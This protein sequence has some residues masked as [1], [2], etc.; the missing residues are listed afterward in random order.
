[1][2]K[3]M[4]TQYAPA[5]IGPYAQAVCTGEFVFTSGQIA[6]ESKTGKMVQGGIEAQTIKVI[7]NIKAVLNAVGLSLCDIVKTMVFVKNL[8]DFD[9]VND[10]YA[11][12]FSPPYPARSCIEAA[13]LPKDALIEI[14]AVA[15]CR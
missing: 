6:L 1:M 7:D 2:R 9:V 8:D 5:A 11:Q 10:V 3:T 4:N 13:R 15:Q 14:E 12:Y